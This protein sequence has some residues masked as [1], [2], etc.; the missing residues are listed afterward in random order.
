MCLNGVGKRLIAKK[1]IK[2]YKVFNDL[3]KSN[4]DYKTPLSK[5]KDKKGNKVRIKKGQRI[6]TSPYRKTTYVEGSVICEKRDIQVLYYNFSSVRVIERGI[7]SLTSKKGVKEVFKSIDFPI[8][9]ECIIPKGT[10]YYRGK[11][12]SHGSIASEKLI[13]NKIIKNFK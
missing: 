6:L 12:L 10:A 8:V 3:G 13:I 7:H 4:R 9:C 5:I 11:F 1:D 2:V